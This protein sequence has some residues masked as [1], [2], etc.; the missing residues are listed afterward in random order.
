MNYEELS[1]INTE[2]K[3]TPV[4]GKPYVMVNDRV[5][6]F[7]R[8]FSGGAITTECI[9]YEPDE[10]C[11]FKAVITDENGVILATGWAQETA[12]KNP[13]FKH[14]LVENCETSA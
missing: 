11:L 10:Y 13:K 1:A 9:K 14:S 2:L 4:S 12:T 8:L 7:R 6:G 5:Q 3:K